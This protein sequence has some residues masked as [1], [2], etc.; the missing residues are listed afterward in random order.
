[1]D[2]ARGEVV[3]DSR[4][5]LT[6]GRTQWCG[7]HAEVAHPAALAP[8]RVGRRAG[9]GREVRDVVI[10]L[11]PHPQ[12]SR[13]HARHANPVDAGARIP[14]PGR[15]RAFGHPCRRAAPR[16]HVPRPDR[17]NTLPFRVTRESPVTHKRMKAPRVHPQPRPQGEL[18][19]HRDILGSDATDH[20]MSARCSSTRST[21]VRNWAV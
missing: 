4:H 3:E 11:V 19:R 18:S 21:L 10:R 12:L 2:H 1:V 8:Q 20:G 15:R 13:V 5:Q 6:R 17:P 9:F 16:R 7:T 14:S